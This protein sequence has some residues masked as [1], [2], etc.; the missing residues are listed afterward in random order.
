MDIFE[1]MKARHSVR[2]YKDQP[3]EEAVRQELDAAI[4]K[5]NAAS[6]LSIQALYDEPT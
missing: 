2:Q 1:T 6:G 5:A 4:E 3:I